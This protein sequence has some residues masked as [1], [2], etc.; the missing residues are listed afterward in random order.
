MKTPKEFVENLKKGIITEEMLDSCLYSV[1]K[2][3]KNWRD[4]KREY[5]GWHYAKHDYSAMA[6]AQEEQMY[7]RKEILLSAT[8]PVCIHREPVNYPR[9]RIY[10]YD[11]DFIDR[12][13]EHIL[14]NDIVWANSYLE[15]NS[16]RE[17]KFFDFED[18]SK[19]VW[20]YYLFY[21][22]SNHSYHTPIKESE[23]RKYDLPVITINKLE[24]QGD[25]ISQLISVQFVDKVISLITEGHFE[26]LDFQQAEGKARREEITEE[27]DESDESD[28]SEKTRN[29]AEIA[30]AWRAW[31]SYLNVGKIINLSKYLSSD[32]EPEEEEKQEMEKLNKTRIRAKLRK[33]IKKMAHSKKCSQELFLS[34]TKKTPPLLEFVPEPKQID[35]MIAFCEENGYTFRNC[36]Q[37]V[38]TTDETVL[39]N[40][41]ANRNRINSCNRYA[42]KL[43]PLWCQEVMEEPE[44]MDSLSTLNIKYQDACTDDNNCIK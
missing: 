12:L 10:D 44:F 36:I 41:T 42:K 4:K 31:S 15:R 33:K 26:C 38:L 20:R 21:Q 1:N 7:R 16:Y 2:R 9:I 35:A 27:S 13:S 14:K 37:A 40:M 25:E 3:A 29:Y 11:N 23:T 30:D 43:F 32:V 19:P 18:R 17:V 22:L 6:L 28:E 8:K 5:K 34:V 39:Q 24:T